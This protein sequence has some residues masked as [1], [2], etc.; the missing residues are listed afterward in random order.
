MLNIVIFGAPGS[1]KG[2][3]SE[4]IVEKYGI[5]HISTG[6][7]LRAE[8]K[9]G[10]ELGK[11]AKGYIDQG[12]LIPDELMIDILASVF[13]SF[14]DSKGVIFDGF[15]RTI[16]QAEALKKML[17]E[18]GQDV[19]VM[20]DLDVPEEELMV[21]LIKRGKDSGRA[22]DNEETIKKRLHVYH[23]Q[24]A[25]LIDWY[26]N[27]KKYQHINGLGTMEGIFAEICE[28]VDKI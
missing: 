25:P 27:E 15:P 4:R 16:A 1:G 24:T 6:D 17:A 3:Q 10:T 28:A 22:D 2:T 18:R 9:N 13:D 23:S 14:K 12:Q 8:I 26:K 11:T 5:N 19:S 20:V 21:R 7:V